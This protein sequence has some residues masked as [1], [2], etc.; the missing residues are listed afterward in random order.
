MTVETVQSRVLV[1]SDASWSTILS[2]RGFGSTLEP[3]LAV[4]MASSDRVR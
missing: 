2:A 4:A 3:A 1:V